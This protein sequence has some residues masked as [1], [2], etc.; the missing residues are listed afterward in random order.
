[1]HGQQVH[2]PNASFEMTATR[3]RK[4]FRFVGLLGGVLAGSLMLGGCVTNS[5][6]RERGYDR[7]AAQDFGEAR[8]Y[9]HQAAQ[10]N[11]R[12]VLAQYYLGLN[13]LHLN[14]PRAAQTALEQALELRPNDPALTPKILDA[15]ASAI[16]RQGRIAELNAFLSDQATR[17]GTSRD[18]QRHAEYLVQAGDHDGARLAFQKAAR[19]A[20]PGD[21]SP[22][23]AIA[24][25][26]ESLGDRQNAVTALRYAYWVD[27]K[28]PSIPQRFRAY[29]LVPGPTLKLE[30]QRPQLLD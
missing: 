28:D 13:E 19:F 11:P 8:S 20:A 21:G 23:L 17:R 27:P 15:L 3:F 18:Y 29:D 14:R 1:M 30:P 24:D 22:Y 26:Y 7:M 2:S 9:F 12:D 4:R 16:F 10:Q 6:L 5:M 25:F